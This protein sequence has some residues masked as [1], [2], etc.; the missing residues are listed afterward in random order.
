M[1]P[2][3]LETLLRE[4]AS[5]PLP[6]APESLAVDVWREIDRRRAERF[7]LR[8]LA[9]LSWRELFAEPRVAAIAFACTLLIGVLP[10]LAA[11]KIH[12][13]QRLARQSLH[14]DVF[15]MGEASQFTNLFTKTAEA[16]RLP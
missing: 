3:P 2:D 8:S 7:W 6:S 5:E 13:D 9:R 16:R 1:A 4:Y 11:T 12:G 10:A 15:A 14:F